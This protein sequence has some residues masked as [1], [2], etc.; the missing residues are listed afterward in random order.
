VP[1]KTT[2]GDEWRPY[3]PAATISYAR[4]W[5]LFRT[6]N[7]AFLMANTHK[8]GLSLFD[9]L[10]PAWAGLYSGPHGQARTRV[11]G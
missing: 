6:P 1:R 9:I 4:H 11:A 8:D 7:D 3:S 5:R 10:Q 2:N